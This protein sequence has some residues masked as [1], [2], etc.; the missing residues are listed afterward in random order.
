MHLNYDTSMRTGGLV[1]ATMPSNPM[2][3]G[4]EP[5]DFSMTSIVKSVSIVAVTELANGPSD[6]EPELF[7]YK[8]QYLRE[9]VHWLYLFPTLRRLASSVSHLISSRDLYKDIRPRIIG[10]LARLAFS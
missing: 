8:L 9:R 2:F 1:G 7:L 4:Y 10:S 3:V 6:V 5:M